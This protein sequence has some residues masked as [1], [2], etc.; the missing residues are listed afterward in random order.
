M[1]QLWAYQL[2]TRPHDIARHWLWNFLI[3]LQDVRIGSPHECQRWYSEYHIHSATSSSQ[4]THW[5]LCTEDPVLKATFEWS[6]ALEKFKKS[7]LTSCMTI[8]LLNG[9]RW[10]HCSPLE[11]QFTGLSILSDNCNLN[12]TSDDYSNGD[13]NCLA[14]EKSL[15]LLIIFFFARTRAEMVNFKFESLCLF[16]PYDSPMGYKKQVK[17]YLEYHCLYV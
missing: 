3:A 11:F 4:A 17:L 12:C 9:N 8:Y 7:N 6:L 1:Y 10:V 15:M 14:N 5:R 13:L 16:L 2:W